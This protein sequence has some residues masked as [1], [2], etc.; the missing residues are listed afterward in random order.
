MKVGSQCK[1]QRVL[2]LL[3]EYLKEAA[4]VSLQKSGQRDIQLLKK[5]RKLLP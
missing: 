2:P 3:E 1:R 5:Q 4:D